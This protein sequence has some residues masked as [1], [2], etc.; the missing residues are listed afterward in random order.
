MVNKVELNN[1]KEF[2]T[3]DSMV[4]S[5]IL[6]GKNQKKGYSIKKIDI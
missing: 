4:G 6:V 5:G 1:F 2:S 3:V